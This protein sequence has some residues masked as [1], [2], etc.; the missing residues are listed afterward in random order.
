MFSS[1][2]STNTETYT[3]PHK[4]AHTHIQTHIRTYTHTHTYNMHAHAHTH[5]PGQS[6]SACPT[7]ATHQEFPL[8]THPGRERGAKLSSRPR[9][10]GQSTLNPTQPNSTTGW[11]PQQQITPTMNAAVYRVYSVR[12]WM[13]VLCKTVCAHF[14]QL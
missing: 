1:P 5:S 10:T 4:Q 8:H 6:F 14:I 12:I 7:H 11:K 2:T 9:Y 13:W 3:H